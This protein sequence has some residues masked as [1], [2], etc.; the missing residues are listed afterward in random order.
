M[1][2]R[3]A[4]TYGYTGKGIAVA[5]IDS[6]VGAH[7]DLRDPLTVASHLVYSEDFTGQGTTEDLYGRGTHVAGIIAG[8]RAASTGANYTVT[9]RGVASG[10]RIVNLRAL[11]SDGKGRTVRSSPPSTAQSH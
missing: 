6:G 7:P 5:V 1:G 9:V 2:A 4:E 8:N 3:L 10:V 11:G